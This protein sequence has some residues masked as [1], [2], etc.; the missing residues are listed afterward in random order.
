MFRSIGATTKQIKKNVLYE[1]FI[2]GIIGIPI[3]YIM[4]IT[5]CI[6]T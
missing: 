6:Y 2:L 4:W 1:A 5:S 3:R